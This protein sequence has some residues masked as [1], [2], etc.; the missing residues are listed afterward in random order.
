MVTH[1]GQRLLQQP[2]VVSSSVFL[3]A[4]P[5]TLSF[6]SPP[7]CFLFCGFLPSVLLLLEEVLAT[8]VSLRVR[9]E[10]SPSS[11]IPFTLL[12]CPFLGEGYV[13]GVRVSD[14]TR[15]KWYE[16]SADTVK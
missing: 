13:L 10:P 4:T 1:R 5:T 15:G 2:N 7:S 6:L 8:S 12:T 9:S 14:D 16:V 3:T 11:D